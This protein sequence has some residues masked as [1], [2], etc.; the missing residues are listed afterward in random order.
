VYTSIKKD[1]LPPEFFAITQN[2]LLIQGRPF[3]E[4]AEPFFG[5]G[6]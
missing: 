6:Y 2:P 5:H 3:L 4:E 1:G